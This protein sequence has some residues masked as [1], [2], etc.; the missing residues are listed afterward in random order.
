MSKQ[1]EI[2]HSENGDRWFLCRDDDGR[3]FVLHQ[4]K[5]TFHPAERRP[6]SRWGTFSEEARW[7]LSIKRSS[8]LSAAW[9]ISQSKK[10]AG[11]ECQG[12]WHGVFIFPSPS[13]WPPYIAGPDPSVASVFNVEVAWIKWDIGTSGTVTRPRECPGFFCYPKFNNLKSLR[14]SLATLGQLVG[15]SRDPRHPA[16]FPSGI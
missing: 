2:Y 14:H 7:D 11:R 4:A 5:P 16:P 12:V 8:I 10:T 3:V 13:V 1:R 15:T 9:S 6:K